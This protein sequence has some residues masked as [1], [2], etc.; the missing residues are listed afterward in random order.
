MASAALVAML[1]TP[2][3]S[4]D[5]MGFKGPGWYL[6]T[7]ALVWMI[8]E[9]PYASKEDCQIAERSKVSSS[10][11]ENGYDCVYMASE[12]DLERVNGGN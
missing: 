9:G 11:D 4:S 8:D 10:G 6:L 7:N 12:S 1:S 2:S 3:Q 5:S